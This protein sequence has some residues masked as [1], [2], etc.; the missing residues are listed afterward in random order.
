MG[1]VSHNTRLCQ[2]A[3]IEHM[4]EIRTHS[5]GDTTDDD[6][7]DHRGLLER[8]LAPRLER[9]SALQLHIVGSSGH[10][11]NG[12]HVAA[13]AI[14]SESDVQEL[15]DAL[16]AERC[17]NLNQLD[18]ALHPDYHGAANFVRSARGGVQ[19]QEQGEGGGKLGGEHRL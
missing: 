3:N 18:G 16:L 2:E 10:G 19:A 1:N 4:R 14:E 9:R 6:V 8:L 15:G 5:P 17:R 12:R 13:L 7:A 11:A